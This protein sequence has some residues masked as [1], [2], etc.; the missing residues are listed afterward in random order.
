MT[1]VELEGLTQKQAANRLGLSVFGMRSPVQPG[2][3]QLKMRLEKC[4]VIERDGRNGVIDLSIT[5]RTHR[6]LD[7]Q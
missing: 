4:C 6:L 3:K 7:R 2:R 5:D 1:L